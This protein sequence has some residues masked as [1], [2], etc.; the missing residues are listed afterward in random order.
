ME[1]VRGACLKNSVH[2]I[3]EKIY[4]MGFLKGRG[5]AVLTY[6]TQGS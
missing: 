6:K 4:K 2:I 5:V 1:R 3:V